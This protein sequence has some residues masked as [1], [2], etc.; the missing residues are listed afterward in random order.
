MHKVVLAFG[1]NDRSHPAVQTGIRNL[2][3]TLKMARAAFPRASILVPVVN[4]SRSLP[5]REQENLR[6][7]NDYIES[8]CESVPA[9]ARNSF[10]VDR[11]GV[12][13]SRHTA[14]L[15]LDHWVE[16]LN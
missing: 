6:R 5:R 11:D 7:L 1:L 3:K 16:A 2:V 9:L 14:S 4:F 10:V 13:W 15:I 12:H 8:R